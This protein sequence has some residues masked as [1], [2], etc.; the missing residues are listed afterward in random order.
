VPG[1]PEPVVR[2]MF[3]DIADRYDLLNDVL[4]LGL[5]RRWRRMAAGAAD[6]QLGRWVLD[7]GCGTGRL[8]LLLTGRARVVGVDLSHSMLLRARRRSARLGLLVG[9][10]MRL[11]LRDA[12]CGAVVSAFVL[13]NLP[14]LSGAFREVARVLAPGGTIALLDLTAPSRPIPRRAL[15]WYL[16]VVGPTA[17][18]MVG[19]REAYEYLARSLVQLPPAD[20]V[21]SLLTEAGMVACAARPSRLGIVTLFTARLPVG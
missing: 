19:K 4:S 8:G 9:T 15:D 1:P 6:V 20:Q 21:C 18:A 14:D 10:A 7:L 17:G 2:A 16:R 5:H 3:D 12:S 13:R 11:P